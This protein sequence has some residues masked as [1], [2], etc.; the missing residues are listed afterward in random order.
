M[1]VVGEGVRNIEETLVRLAVE[2][3]WV[4]GVV[5]RW[6]ERVSMEREWV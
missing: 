6:E 2:G 3:E 5:L 4:F 1:I